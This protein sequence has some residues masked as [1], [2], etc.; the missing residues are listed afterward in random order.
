LLI[1]VLVLRAISIEVL[2]VDI[3]KRWLIN[4]AGL[5]LLK[6]RVGLLELCI[7]FDFVLWLGGNDFAAD[8]AEVSRLAGDESRLVG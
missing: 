5:L 3:G 2:V 1:I 6:E 7:G 4:V 8:H